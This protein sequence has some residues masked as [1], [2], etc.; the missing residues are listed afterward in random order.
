MQSPPKGAR[1]TG[2]K[3]SSDRLWKQSRLFVESRCIEGCKED[4][5]LTASDAVDHG[6]SELALGE[7]ISS[8]FVEAEDD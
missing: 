8:D 3:P 5:R 1:A 7:I 2:G 4:E 6:P